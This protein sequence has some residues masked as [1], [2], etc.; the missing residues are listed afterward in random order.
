LASS[1]PFLVGGEDHCHLQQEKNTQ[2][3]VDFKFSSLFSDLL[4]SLLL[5]HIC[6]F[7][8]ADPFFFSV[9]GGRR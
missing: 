9:S 8:S 2:I 3:A 6:F 4:L 7:L 1:L 5:F